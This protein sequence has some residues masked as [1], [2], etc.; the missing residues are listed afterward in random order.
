MQTGFGEVAIDW[1]L[2]GASLSIDLKVPFGVTAEL[3]LPATEQS[4]LT[5]N[6]ST[7]ELGTALTHG[8][9]QIALTNPLVIA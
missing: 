2:S 5:V 1:K 9:Y 3:H 8:S 6:G 7:A 4:A